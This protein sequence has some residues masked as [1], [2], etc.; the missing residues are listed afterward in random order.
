MEGRGRW[1]DGCVVLGGAA[2]R[3]DLMGADDPPADGGVDGGPA[4]VHL[5]GVGEHDEDDD[6]GPADG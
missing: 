6:R 4:G 3:V 1:V 5:E 2:G